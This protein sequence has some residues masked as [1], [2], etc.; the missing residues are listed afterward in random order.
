MV[1]PLRSIWSA[2]VSGC[3]SEI[4]AMGVDEGVPF[5]DGDLAGKDGR[6]A[7]IR[8]LDVL[9]EVTTGTDVERFEAPIVEVRSWTPVRLRSMR[10]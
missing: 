7:P 4:D 5:V 10:A 3:R 8:V 1:N 9:I 6:A 2:C